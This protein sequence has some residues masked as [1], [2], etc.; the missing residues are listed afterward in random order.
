MQKCLILLLAVPYDQLGGRHPRY[1][2]V[3]IY[4]AK[5]RSVVVAARQEGIPLPPAWLAEYEKAERAAITGLARGP[6]EP[7]GPSAAAD[8]QRAAV[9]ALKELGIAPFADQ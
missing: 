5:L 8:R 4:R 1:M 6:A 3:E 7:H 2:V 9:A